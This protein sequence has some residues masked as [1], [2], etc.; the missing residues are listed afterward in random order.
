MHKKKKTRQRFEKKV[1]LEKRGLGQEKTAHRR[2]SGGGG[3]GNETRFNF[4]QKKKA[5]T[6]TQRQD[7]H[8]KKKALD[9]QQES[10]AGGRVKE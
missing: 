4:H 7:P 10:E 9:P 2:D 5:T 1:T 3:D 6:R 8:E